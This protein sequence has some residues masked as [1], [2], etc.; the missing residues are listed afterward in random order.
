M[1]RTMYETLTWDNGYE[2]HLGVTGDRRAVVPQE[3]AEHQRE[4]DGRTF[5]ALTRDGRWMRVRLVGDDYDLHGTGTGDMV[6][7]PVA[8]IQ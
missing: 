8:Y 6:V 3:I 7:R 1:G 5:R 4:W 2:V